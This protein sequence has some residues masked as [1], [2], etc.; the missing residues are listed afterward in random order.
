[1]KFESPIDPFGEHDLLPTTDAQIIAW[2]TSVLTVNQHILRDA[3]PDAHCVSHAAISAQTAFERLCFGDAD[4]NFEVHAASR[5]AAIRK[6]VCHAAGLASF[7]YDNR[8]EVARSA[9]PLIAFM[10]LVA[11]SEME[12][13]WRTCFFRHLLGFDSRT[14]TEI[15]ENL[16]DALSREQALAAAERGRVMINA[17]H[18]EDPTPAKQYPADAEAEALREAAAAH[19]RQALTGEA[20][21][22]P[23]KH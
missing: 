4:G 14:S 9:E 3:Y 5:R 18:Q 17:L 12:H 11:P 13:A 21:A 19:M 8:R 1:M 16:M 6:T 22:L 20:P 7:S 15:T 10:I 23:Y 2:F